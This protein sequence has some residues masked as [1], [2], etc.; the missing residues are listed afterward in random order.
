MYL[1]S[2]FLSSTGFF[3]FSQSV[4]ILFHLKFL[5]AWNL[6]LTQ[7][8]QIFCETPQV[9]VFPLLPKRTVR[10]P[11]SLPGC[12]C[13]LKIS[14]WNAANLSWCC[15]SSH[16]QTAPPLR[17]ACTTVVRIKDCRLIF[18]FLLLLLLSAFSC[19]VHVIAYR[20]AL[21]THTHTGLPV[22]GRQ[23]WKVWHGVGLTDK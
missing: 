20:L 4:G 16:T 7:I 22:F 2:H 23:W 12:P 17:K 11:I 14:M 8:N 10:R 19:A 13:P 18:F 15:C 1:S 9:V 5:L 6:R 3:F 21:M